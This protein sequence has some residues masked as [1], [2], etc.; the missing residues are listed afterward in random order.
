MTKRFL[1]GVWL[2]AVV[3]VTAGASTAAQAAE[4][5]ARIPFPFIVNGKALPAG[6]YALAEE[7]G[8]L[9][10]RGDRGAAVVLTQGVHSNEP[11]KPQ[12]VFHRYGDEY[13]LRQAWT[14]GSSGRELPPPRQERELARAARGAKTAAVARVVIP[15]L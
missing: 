6:S 14:G 7:R 15:A 8:M 11:V 10:V 3:A 1:K 2:A 5:R 9:W 4:V 12:L 13:I